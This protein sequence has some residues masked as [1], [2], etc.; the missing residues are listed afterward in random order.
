M[1]GRDIRVTSPQDISAPQSIL[2]YHHICKEAE[3]IAQSTHRP[4][5]EV[6]RTT[7]SDMAPIWNRAFSR[8]SVD[9]LHR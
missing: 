1:R 9:N 7:Q 6:I 8:N 5:R 3:N 2:D 4:A